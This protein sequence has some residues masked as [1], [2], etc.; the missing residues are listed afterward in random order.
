VVLAAETIGGSRLGHRPGQGGPSRHRR[1]CSA[2]HE[3]R[4]FTFIEILATLVLLAIVLPAVMTGISLSLSAADF[5]KRQAEAADL[6][7]NKLMELLTD[8]QWQSASLAGDFGT[9]YPEYR[10]TAEATDWQG[11]VLLRELELTVWW[12]GG[13]KDRSLVLSTLVY[14]GG[15]S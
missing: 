14:T 3:G 5:A 1:C 9:Q 4:A 8:G 11:G 15:Q 6:G 7:Q 12:R 2:R 10:W 13:G